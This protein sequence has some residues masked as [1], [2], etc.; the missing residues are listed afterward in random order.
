MKRVL[1]V[2]DEQAIA[3]LV[4]QAL[5]RHGFETKIAPDGDE[6]LS[7]IFELKPDIVIL[8]LMLPKMD[9]WEVCRRVKNDPETSHIPIM[10]LTARRSDRDAVEGLELGA[11][12][13]MRKPFS[14][15]EL[16]A[17][18]RALLRRGAPQ[19]EGQNVMANGEALLDLNEEQLLLYGEAITLS[20]TE[21]R[22]IEPLFRRFGKA[23][24]RE[25]LLGRIWNAN[26]GD[27]RTVDVHISRMRRKFEG[28]D[29]GK[30]PR[31]VIQSMRGKGYR[32]VWQE[33]K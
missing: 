14:C 12:D 15:D 5:R 27:T 21:F 13:Y 24:S 19:A 9:G 2:E 18:V 31:L 22:L 8:D 3:D 11:D 17:R 32:L 25:E 26:L 7:L 6:A 23:V 20:P 4:S 10:M 30:A 16:S 1:I 28:Y 29:G 33:K